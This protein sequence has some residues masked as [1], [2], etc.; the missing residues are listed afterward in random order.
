[1]FKDDKKYFMYCTKC[2]FANENGSSFCYSC[3]ALIKAVSDENRIFEE[4]V[5][6]AAATAARQS[7][8]IKQPF[9]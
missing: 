7:S 5:F 1:M 6:S 2:G 3:C 8:Y 9:Y 4:P